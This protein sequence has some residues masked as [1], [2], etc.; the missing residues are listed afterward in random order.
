MSGI[1]IPRINWSPVELASRAIRRGIKFNFASGSP[2]PSLIP[3]NLIKESM[4]DL[5]PA[6]RARA[7]RG[8][9]GYAPF[10][11]ATRL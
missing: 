9:E 6:F 10:T 4:T 11:G 1:R 2:D 5:L 7:P 3:I 8:L